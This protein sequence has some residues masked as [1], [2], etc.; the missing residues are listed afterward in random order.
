MVPV[1]EKGR[2]S[3]QTGGITALRCFRMGLETKKREK[4]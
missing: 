4:S 2:D 1:F 3:V